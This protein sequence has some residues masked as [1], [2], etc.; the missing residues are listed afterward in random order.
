MFDRFW[1]Y[2]DQAFK[3]INL[4]PKQVANNTS[5]GKK[6][7]MRGDLLELETTALFSRILSAF[8]ATF[9]QHVDC[10]N[11]TTKPFLQEFCMQDLNLPSLIVC[12]KL[13]MFCILSGDKSLSF[14]TF[15]AM[16]CA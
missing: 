1:R 8:F 15:F 2:D 6:S 9:S 12:I 11:R 3:R 7:D 14:L 4:H 16:Q 10:R 5:G 13:C